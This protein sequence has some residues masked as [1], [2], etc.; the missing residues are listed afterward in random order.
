MY[1]EQ[2]LRFSM[3]RLLKQTEFFV[4]FFVISAAKAEDNEDATVDP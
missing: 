4:I 1:K 2:D 3:A